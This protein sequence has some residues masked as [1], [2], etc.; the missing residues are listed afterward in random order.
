SNNYPSDLI[1]EA[2]DFS[3]IAIVTFSRQ[4]GEGGDLP[5]DMAEYNGDVGKHYLE[6]QDVERSLL[7]K[8]KE[9][10]GTVIV[11]INSS[12]A[13]ELGFLEEEGV[14]AALWIGGPGSTGAL[15]IGKILS[16]EVNPS[17]RLVDTY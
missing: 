3:D 10:F 2:K 4:G 6:L 16:G 5:M 17:G 13:M 1:S 9:N 7:D 11:L 8:V 12:N 15:A 14:D